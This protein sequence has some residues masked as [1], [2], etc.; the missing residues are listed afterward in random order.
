MGYTY[1]PNLTSVNVRFNPGGGN[2]AIGTAF[3]EVQTP[4]V[5]YAPGGTDILPHDRIIFGSRIFDVE[6]VNDTDELGILLKIS[7]KEVT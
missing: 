3:L 2:I 4:H 5:I 7:A 1:A 6:N